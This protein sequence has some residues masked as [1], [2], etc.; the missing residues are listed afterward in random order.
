MLQFR[1]DNVIRPLQLIITDHI[2]LGDEIVGDNI[3]D[4]GETI[5][6]YSIDG[7]NG[8]EY[9]WQLEPENAGFIIDHGNAVDIVWDFRHDPTSATLSVTSN[10]GCIQE[11]LSKDIQINVV[12]T[13]EERLSNFSIYPNPTD[14]KVNLTIGQDLQGKS[15]IEVYNVLGTCLTSKTYQ[16]LTKGQ[17]IAFDLQHFAPGIYIIKLCN[18]EGC[19]S[20]KVSIR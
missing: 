19:W 11:T 9:V 13:P 20:Q 14:G 2:D 3:I 18:D 4:D 8:V 12:S 7:V 10:A 15:V 16:S 17:S 1:V 6:H 5:S